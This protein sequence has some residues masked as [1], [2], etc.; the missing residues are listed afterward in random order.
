MPSKYPH[1][2][3]HTGEALYTW[4]TEHQRDGE[5]LS[6]TARRLLIDQMESTGRGLDADWY[7][8]AATPPASETQSAREKR[9]NV[10]P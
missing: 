7:A 9:R 6:Q 4:L 5:S 10:R 2:H 1:A 8:Q 3:F